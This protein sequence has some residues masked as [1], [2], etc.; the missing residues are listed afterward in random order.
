MTAKL[1][2]FWGFIARIPYGRPAGYLAATVVVA[3]AAAP[4]AAAG[5]ADW[6]IGCIH[7]PTYS[8]F[9]P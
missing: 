7:S 9:V 4:P 8:V 2:H 1:W 5:A 6:G 3:V